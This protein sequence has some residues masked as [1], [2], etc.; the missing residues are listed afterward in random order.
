MRKK[1][2]LG[3]LLVAFALIMP[4]NIANATKIRVEFC[5]PGNVGLCTD[6][7]DDVGFTC[8]PTSGEK[9]CDGTYWK[10]FG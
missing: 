3:F 6:K 7:P 4:S 8:E 1:I 9:D 2:I 5:N 10:T